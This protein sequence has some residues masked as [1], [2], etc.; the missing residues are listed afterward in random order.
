MKPELEASFG[1][2]ISQEIS[3]LM[4]SMAGVFEENFSQIRGRLDEIE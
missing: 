2:T 3:D 4:L 1:A